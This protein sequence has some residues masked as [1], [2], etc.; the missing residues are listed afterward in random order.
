VRDSVRD[1]AREEK[2]RRAAS[3][4]I[5]AIPEPPIPPS[6]PSG[7]HPDVPGVDAKQ[8]ARDLRRQLGATLPRAGT[9]GLIAGARALERNNQPRRAEEM[10]ARSRDPIAR[11]EL[12]LLQRKSGRTADAQKVLAAFAATVED[13][14]WPAPLL[15]AYLGELKDGAVIAAAT[16]SDE[17]C[18]A[19]YYLGRLREADDAEAARRHLEAAASEHCDHAEVAAEELKSLQRR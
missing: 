8:L 16:D 7:G 12:F 18:E 13:E 19:E 10:L 15:R 6:P 2:T 3:P 9:I 1:S 17:R 11:L 4:R 14:D 5:P